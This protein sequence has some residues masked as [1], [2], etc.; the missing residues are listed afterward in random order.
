[1]CIT[2]EEKREISEDSNSK[3]DVEE[4]SKKAEKLAESIQ[5]EALQEFCS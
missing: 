2:H 3:E 4:E 1:V 5:D